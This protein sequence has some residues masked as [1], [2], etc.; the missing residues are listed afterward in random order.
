MILCAGEALID[1]LPRQTLTGEAAFAPRPGG[2][3]FNTAVALGRLGVPTG[4]LCGL[5]RDLFGQLLVRALAEAGVDTGL[6]PRLDRPT[7]LAFVTLEDGQARYAFHDENTALR[8][9]TP[10]DL[11][12]LP[13]GVTALFLGGISLVSEPCGSAFAALAEPGAAG[14][15]VVMLDPNIRPGFVRD[16]PAYRTRLARLMARVDIVKLSDED[17]RW[18]APGRP[19]GA[20]IAALQAAGPA[21]VLLTRGAA[22]AEA[23]HAGGVVQ[24]PAVPVRVA[25][26]VGAGD[27]F[28]AG[29]LA[30]LTRA[31]VL[32][33]AALR[34]LAPEV[35][36][37]ALHLGVR[38]AAVTVSRPGADPPWAQEL[39]APGAPGSGR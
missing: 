34:V 18:L 20:A 12:P 3:V 39:A 13:Q 11:R 27:T 4:F 32:E 1:M 16:E 29:V 6:C 5:S 14:D 15:R 23:Y 26:T 30:G 35:L 33:R 22:G 38:A 10:A 31:G 8:A 2:A 7:T 37:G 25:D 17:L 28:N 21:L 9:L 19:E 24:V 36:A